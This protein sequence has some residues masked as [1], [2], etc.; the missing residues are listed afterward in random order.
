MIDKKRILLYCETVD[1]EVLDLSLILSE[2]KLDKSSPQDIVGNIIALEKT[3]S[4]EE[5][6]KMIWNN[7]NR[8]VK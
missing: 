4:E 6:I 3:Y 2:L 7:L 8:F 5:F 1:K